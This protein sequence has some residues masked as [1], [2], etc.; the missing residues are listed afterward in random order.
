MLEILLLSYVPSITRH[1]RADELRAANRSEVRIITFHIGVRMLLWTNNNI[2]WFLYPNLP[3][4]V[5]SVIRATVTLQKIER[6]APRKN[7][8]LRSN[9]VSNAPV[10]MTSSSPF[11]IR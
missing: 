7:T 9:R 1:L 4:R 5:V 2:K 6:E 11:E 8:L 3:Y 10:R